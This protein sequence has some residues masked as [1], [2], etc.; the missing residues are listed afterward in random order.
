M[1]TL[2][3][4]CRDG[5]L[6]KVRAAL[7]RGVHVNGKGSFGKTALMQAVSHGHNSIVK[8][9]LD[10]PGVKVNEEN[11]YV[12]TALH[13]AAWSN[14]P[15]GARLLLLHPDFNLANATNKNGFTALHCAANNNNPEV[16][17]LLL[18]HPGFNSANAT[19]DNGYT[20]LHYAAMNNNPEVARLLLLH[21]GFNS[22]NATDND[23]LTA[24][25]YAVKNRKKEVLVEL[26]RHDSISLEIP[27]GEFDE[28]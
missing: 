18:L 27:D 1:P 4:L 12:N 17:R 16:V 3:K 5:K 26:V 22:A 15:E 24:L 28:R 6:V 20:A 25:M 23:G 8:L 9:L 21:S 19:D 13:Y 2:R 10:Q 14:N 7:A 11:I